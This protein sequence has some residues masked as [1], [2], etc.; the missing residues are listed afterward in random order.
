M[1]N[2]YDIGDVVRCSSTFTDTGGNKADPTTVHFVHTTPDQTD[3]VNT[4]TST[5]T[6][7]VDTIYKVA[8]GVYYR[9]ITIGSSSG[10]YWYRFSS[11]GLITAADEAVFRVRRQYTST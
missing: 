5:S 8:T 4:R 6:G 11:T 10:A 3:T 1:A 7:L 2:A 9:D